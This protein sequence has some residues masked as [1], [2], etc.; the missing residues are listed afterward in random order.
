MS[1]AGASQ[2]GTNYVQD[3]MDPYF[4]ANSL[5][6][7]KSYSRQSTGSFC[8]TSS[9]IENKTPDVT[10]LSP[11]NLTIPIQTPFELEGKGTDD[12]QSQLAYTWEPVSYTH[13]DVYKRQTPCW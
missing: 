1:Y 13:L 10:I 5:R 8:G 6:Q 7:I 11:S 4:H 3:M 12:R 2:C 9:L